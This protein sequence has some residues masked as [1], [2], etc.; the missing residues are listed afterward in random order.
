MGQIHTLD[1]VRNEVNNPT[2]AANSATGFSSPN[3]GAQRRTEG[4]RFFTPEIR[5][6]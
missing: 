4:R 2:V 5:A 6:V 3:A 1:A